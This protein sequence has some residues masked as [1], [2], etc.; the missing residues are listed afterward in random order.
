MNIFNFK[1]Y[2]KFFIKNHINLICNLNIF[3]ILPFEKP[4]NEV[5][6]LNITKFNYNGI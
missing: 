2:K 1:K 6:L 5:I 4:K 3:I